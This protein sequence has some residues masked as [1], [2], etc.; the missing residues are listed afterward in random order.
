MTN[1]LK[2][3]KLTFGNEKNGIDTIMRS[4]PERRNPP[5]HIPTHRRSEGS[6]KLRIL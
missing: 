1:N 4:N 6:A 2:M 5:H 3:Q